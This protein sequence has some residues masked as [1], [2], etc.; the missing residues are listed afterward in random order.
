M[1]EQIDMHRETLGLLK[2]LDGKTKNA[3]LKAAIA[4]AKPKVQAHLDQAKAVK[5][6]D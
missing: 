3:D 5:K 2:D 6:A 1:D 4:A